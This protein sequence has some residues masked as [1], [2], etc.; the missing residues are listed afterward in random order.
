MNE[1]SRSGKNK[2]SSHKRNQSQAYSSRNKKNEI[3]HFARNKNQ[4]VN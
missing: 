2:D 1:G 4:K 3:S